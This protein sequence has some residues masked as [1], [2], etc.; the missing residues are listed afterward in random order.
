ME[1]RR[2]PEADGLHEVTDRGQ[3]RERPLAGVHDSL[4]QYSTLLEINNAIISNLTQESPC[5]AV[6]EAL[7][8]VVP[9]GRAVLFVAEKDGLRAVG[10]E[11]GELE[12]HA[13]G[14]H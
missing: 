14:A 7:R 10:L 1:D 9:F 2:E 3:N 13:H 12:G 4:Q 11:G 5:H 8:T 6:S